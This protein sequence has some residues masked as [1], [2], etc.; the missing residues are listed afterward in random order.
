MVTQGSASSSEEGTTATAISTC[1][2]PLNAGVSRSQRNT[3]SAYDN[4]SRHIVHV[5]SDD[6][7]FDPVY[8][9]HLNEEGFNVLYEHFTGDVNNFNRTIR[10]LSDD[11]EPG[12]KYAIIAFG[13]AATHT[14]SA[15]QQT[16]LPHC[17][18]LICYYPTA[19]PA[20]THKYPASLDI[21]CH[22]AS[23][24][25]FGAASFK[26]YVYP[27]VCPGFAESDLQEY[28]KFAA[29]L[30]WGRTLA[31]LRR[32]FRIVVDLEEV[33]DEYNKC[34]FVYPDQKFIILCE[35]NY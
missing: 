27:D 20:P 12:Q 21:L 32:G 26:I 25:P 8:L 34:K 4:M 29:G 15:A 11:L 33:V 1:R 23:M 31:C 2:N 3:S 5:L 6:I 24:Q 18:S 35:R 9:Q 28:D 16:S 22:L 30:S 13:E 17:V 7:E 10:H 19:V 14:L